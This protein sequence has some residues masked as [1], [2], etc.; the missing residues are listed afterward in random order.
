[1]EKINTH[2]AYNKFKTKDF[3]YKELFINLLQ[4]PKNKTS[5]A[6]TMVMM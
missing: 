2:V 1:M 6:V 5:M 3:I 4:S